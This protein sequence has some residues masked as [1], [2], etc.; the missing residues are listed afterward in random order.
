MPSTPDPA[1]RDLKGLRAI[2]VNKDLREKK[3]TTG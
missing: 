1:R 3:A 2:P